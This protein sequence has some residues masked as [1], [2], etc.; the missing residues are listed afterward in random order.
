[1]HLQ[2]EERWGSRGWGAGGE[3]TKPKDTHSPRRANSMDLIA[4]VLR[5]PVVT[6][7]DAASSIPSDLKARIWKAKEKKKLSPSSE[8]KAN[9]TP[10]GS[11]SW[12]EKKKV[13]PRYFAAGQS[14][15]SSK[16]KIMTAS[17]CLK[18]KFTLGGCN[19]GVFR[20]GMWNVEVGG[21]GGEATI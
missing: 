18:T 14:N 1:M 20:G 3:G 12:R 5:V 6:R 8:L 11:A 10:T 7:K 2:E 21:G 15:L 13:N 19:G 16:I 17:V 9:T 4:V